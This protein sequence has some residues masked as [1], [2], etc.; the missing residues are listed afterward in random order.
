MSMMFSYLVIELSKEQEKEKAS[1]IRVNIRTYLDLF[2]C[3]Y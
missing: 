3:F 2:R 1:L